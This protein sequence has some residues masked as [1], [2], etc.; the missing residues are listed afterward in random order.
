[1][2]D[3]YLILTLMCMLGGSLAAAEN[4]RILIFSFFRGNGQAGVYLAASD[5]GV[6]FTPLQPVMKPSPW[7]GQNLT[8]DPSIVFHDG[9][10][11]AVW[12]TNWLGNCW[13][14]AQC[15]ELKPEASVD[16]RKAYFILL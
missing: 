1:M 8:R 15:P 16:V 12:T 14:V 13:L 10:F 5:D 11:H 2:D 4:D 6:K 9:K 3:K 7:E